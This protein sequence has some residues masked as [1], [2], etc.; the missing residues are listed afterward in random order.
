MQFVGPV[1]LEGLAVK[2]GV[3]PWRRIAEAESAGR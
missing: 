2:R 3:A 1:R